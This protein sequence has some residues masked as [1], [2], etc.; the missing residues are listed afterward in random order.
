YAETVPE[1]F[2]GRVTAGSALSDV[3]LAQKKAAEG[4]PFA[5]R[6]WK[7]SQTKGFSP[8]VARKAEA[9]YGEALCSVGRCDEGRPMIEASHEALSAQF[10]PAHPWTRD[11]AQRLIRV[12][13]L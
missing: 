7:A 12:K 3:L 5:E 9:A 8:I 1:T 10:G 4:L 13:K 6:A 2:V 11:V